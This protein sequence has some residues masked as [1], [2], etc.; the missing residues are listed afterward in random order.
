MKQ[1]HAEPVTLPMAVAGAPLAIELRHLRYFVALADAG[2]FT[3][4]AERLFIAQ[5][6]L[7]Q[8]IRRMEEIVGAPLLRR[9][10]DGLQLAAARRAPLEASRTALAQVDQPVSQTRQAA[11]LAR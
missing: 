4:A 1:G 5:P 11:G 3:R 7:S 8:Q 10:P 9:R 2:S 6:T